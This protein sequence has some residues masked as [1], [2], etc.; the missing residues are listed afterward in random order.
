MSHL[1]GEKVKSC[2]EEP[3]ASGGG[4]G[5]G[6]S[7][8]P[9]AGCGLL[10]GRHILDPPSR[11]RL[12]D[13]PRSGSVK[14]DRSC[15]WSRNARFDTASPCWLASPADVTGDPGSMPLSLV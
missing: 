2:D 11:R 6:G 13:P 10:C 9:R 1:A 5:S 3:G 8:T 12:T 14:S 15:L 4:L 7:S